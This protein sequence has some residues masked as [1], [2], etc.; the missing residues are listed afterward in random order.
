MNQTRLQQEDQ[1]SYNDVEWF[2]LLG[3]LIIII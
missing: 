1:K 2:F 3:H